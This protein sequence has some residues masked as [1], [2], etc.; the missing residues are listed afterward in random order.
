MKKN[1]Q[2]ERL[3][4]KYLCEAIPL[5]KNKVLWRFTSKLNDYGS[6]FGPRDG[7]ITISINIKSK[8]TTDVIIHEYAH[9]LDFEKNGYNKEHH[10]DNWGQCYAEV[11]R[12]YL[13][14][15]EEKKIERS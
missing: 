8:D 4:A 6:C 1:H 11:Y 3:L 12:A 10:S 2:Y 7:K 9:A 15:L 5:Q 13:K 14:L